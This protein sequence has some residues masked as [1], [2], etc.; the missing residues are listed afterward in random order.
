MNNPWKV[1]KKDG[2][3]KK[4]GMYLAYKYVYKYGSLERGIKYDPI[5][6]TVK[7]GWNTFVDLDGVLHK[8]YAIND[9]FYDGWLDPF[10]FPAPKEN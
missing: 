3:P 4:D 8:E 7:G 2:V 9:D 1:T 6:F 10:E 5:S